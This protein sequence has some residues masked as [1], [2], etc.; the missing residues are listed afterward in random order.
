M[1]RGGDD[2][3]LL[4]FQEILFHDNPSITNKG[5]KRQQNIYNPSKC[6]AKMIDSIDR[7]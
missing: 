5:N 1:V 3:Q 7:Q 6:L 2:L 4:S